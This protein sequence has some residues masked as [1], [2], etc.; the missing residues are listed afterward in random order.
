MYALEPDGRVLPVHAALPLQRADGRLGSGADGRLDLRAA[1]DRS[2][3]R[4]GLPARRAGG[5]RDLLQLRGQAALL[6]LG[7]ARATR[8]RRQPAGAGLRQRGLGRRRGPLR[9]ALR[10]RRDRLLRLD[11]RR[12]HRAAHARHA[13][14]STRSGA[15]G[16]RRARP[17]HRGGVPAGPL[18]RAGA[19]AQRGGGHRRARVQGR[20][21][22]LR[23]LLAQR[24]GRDAPGCARVGTGRATW[25]TATRPGSSTSPGATTTGCGSTARTSPRPR[26][27]GSCNAIPTSCWPPSTPCPTRSS[28]TRSWWPCSCGPGCDASRRRTSWPAFLAA[29]G[30]LGTKWA[31]R[32]VRM[33]AALPITATNKVLKRALRAE[34]WNCADP[35]LW[36]PEKGG[37]YRRSAPARTRAR[38]RRGRPA[39]LNLRVGFAPKARSALD[40]SNGRLPHAT[41][42]TAGSPCFSMWQATVGTGWVRSRESSSAIDAED[43]PARRHAGPGRDHHVLEAGRPG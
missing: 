8:R 16:H 27:S 2:L 21:R 23:G 15:R 42:H 34:R 39:A 14:G 40:E 1:L 12:R 3:L 29:Q 35:V 19:S 43:Q 11:R 10:R 36:Q 37:P 7:H 38:R 9:R 41:S 22:R 20:R 4:L 6:H 17:G 5:R 24:R 18:R 13:A 28:A 26:S 31:P 25:P 33:S 32:F 30:D